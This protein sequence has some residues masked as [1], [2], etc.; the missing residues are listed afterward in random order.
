MA[1]R[2]EIASKQSDSRA[3]VRKKKLQALGFDSKIQEVTLVDVYTI[4]KKFSKKEISQVAEMLTNPVTQRYSF[5][6]FL[7]P[8]K[9]TY[10]IEIGYLPGVTDNRSEER[11]VGKEC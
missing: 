1:I 11:R 5:I 6:H 9:F 8:R 3:T 7:S 10:A 4:D 2:I